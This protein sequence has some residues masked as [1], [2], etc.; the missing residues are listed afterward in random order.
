MQREINLKPIGVIKTPYKDP[1]GMPIQGTF[2][3]GLTGTIKLFPEYKEG[4]K[5]LDGFFSSYSYL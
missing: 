3:K 4:L 2:E 1:K 5:D